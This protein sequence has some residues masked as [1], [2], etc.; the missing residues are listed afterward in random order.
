M[1]RTLALIAFPLLAAAALAGCGSSSSSPSSTANAAVT[2]SGSFGKAPSVMIPTQKPG[3]TLAVKTLIQGNGATIVKTDSFVSN[4]NLYLWNGTTHKLLD[5]T[6]ST[7]PEALP[8]TLLPGIQSA[9]V[10]QK[11]GSRVLAVIPPKEGYGSSGNSQLGVSGSDTLVFVLD[12][13]QKFSNTASASG[14]Q[15][16]GGGG[17]LPTVSAAHGSAPA[18]TIPKGVTPPKTLAV[19]TL[20][21]GSGPAV[22][23]GQTVVAQYTGVIWRTGQVFDSSWARGTLFSFRVGATPSQVITGWDKGILGQTVGSRVML[24]IPPSDGYGSAGQTQAG[25]KG[26]DTLVFVVDILGAVSP[27]SAS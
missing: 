27:T 6:Y 9:V 15:V 10:G 11:V 12:L 23:K 1:R 25:I 19:K 16:S 24:V 13:I 4:F 20:I 2:A 14:S 26:T 17:S 18:V 7:N 5:S 22:A 3:G 21:K 8:A